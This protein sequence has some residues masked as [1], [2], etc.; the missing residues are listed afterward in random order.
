[1]KTL[2][3]KLKQHT[4]LIHFQHSQEG[5]TLRASELK[6]KLDKYILENAFEESS[7]DD[8][9]TFLVGYDEKKEDVLRVKFER[10]N[11]RAFDYKLSISASNRRQEVTL[12]PRCNPNDGNYITDNFPLLLSNM[13]GKD[14]LDEL[15]DFVYHDNIEL[16]FYSKNEEL[17][18]DI[19][20]WI[21]LF[22]AT[23]NFGQ[24]QDKGF[25]S[26]SVISINGIANNFPHK[27]LKNTRYLSFNLFNPR[28]N[29]RQL[30]LEQKKI[31]DVIDFYWKVL[32][33]G[34]NYTR[35]GQFPN[36]YIK[37]FLWRY[38]NDNGYTWEKRRVKQEFDLTNGQERPGN[39]NQT[40]FARAILGCPDRF[41]YR[42][43]N[44]VV[45]I[46][47]N[48]IARIPSPII[49]KPIINDN[50][51]IKIY[52]LIDESALEE[53]RTRESLNFTFECNN[54]SF[55]LP[56]N[57][58][59]IDLEELLKKYHAF[60]TKEVSLCAFNDEGT[61]E[62]YE[63]NNELKNRQWFIPL[64][65]NWARILGNNRSWVEMYIVK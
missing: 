57:P 48:E 31:F 17:I 38:L 11:F 45:S 30:L 25:G 46:S 6:P 19:K 64:A 47:H 59:V 1:M 14:S 62:E 54:E 63:E 35:N 3:V 50:G 2:T 36:R 40:L 12:H 15:V 44:R 60:L 16:T 7:F 18:E 43:K 39:N 4:P 58:N 27:D 23:H 55:T 41:E 10:E 8:C 20:G 56:V 24:R 5:A 51:N 13:G 37:S 26:F 61:W 9:K 21:D 34:V 52:L 28:N 65:F 22:F 29:N 49:F 32:K 42:N 33:S 53:L